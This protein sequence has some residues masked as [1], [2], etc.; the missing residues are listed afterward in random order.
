MTIGQLAAFAGVTTKAVRHYHERGLLPEPPR[1]AAGYRRYDAE[2]AVHLVKIRTLAAAGVPLARI[3][4]LLAADPD[5]FADAIAEIDRALQ[6][7]AVDIARARE[8]VAQLR[9]GD[10]LF[11]SAEVAELLDRLLA[12]GVSRR[13]VQM[14]RDRWILLQSIAPEQAAS[15]TADKLDAIDDPEFRALYLDFDAAF[16]WSPDDPRLADLA[17]RTRRWLA[18][19][20]RAGP[21]DALPDPMLSR[22]V[23]TSPA[24]SSPAWERLTEITSRHK[25]GQDGAPPETHG[26]APPR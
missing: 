7:R 25:T 23:S 8:R 24:E 15:W 26:G 17:E 1:D 9:T 12:L 21:E 2:H 11:V 19:R 5:R 4:E 3:E 13:A 20:H 14:E 10:R 22:F 16:D 6:Q 18:T